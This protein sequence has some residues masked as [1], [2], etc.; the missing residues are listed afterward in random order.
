MAALGSV[1]AAMRGVDP[2]LPARRRQHDGRAD[3]PDDG[4]APLLGPVLLGGF[5]ALAVVL[6][7]IG[8][9]GVMSYMVTQRTRELGVRLALG[10]AA[11]TCSAWC[12]GRA[13][14]SRSPAWASA[15]WRRSR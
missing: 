9:Y 14:G 15:S 7:S 1:R 12:C 2:D 6:A 11:P 3:R 8:L 4:A 10:A 5:A 13:C